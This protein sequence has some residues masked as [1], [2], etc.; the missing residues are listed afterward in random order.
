MTNSKFLRAAIAGGALALVAL[1]ATWAALDHVFGLGT[2][3]LLLLS[4]LAM[5]RR[6]TRQ[7]AFNEELD[8][9]TVETAG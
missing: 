6:R 5:A 4:L 2:A 1:S 8:N 7:H 3:L 9:F